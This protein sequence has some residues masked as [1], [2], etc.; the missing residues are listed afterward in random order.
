MDQQ[1]SN[2][3]NWVRS[4]HAGFGMT[5]NPSPVALIL[6]APAGERSPLQI[7]DVQAGI[8]VCQK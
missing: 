3:M 8:S 2:G 5:Q 1:A 6:P 4:K 7:G